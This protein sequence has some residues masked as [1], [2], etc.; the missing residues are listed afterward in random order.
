MP[1]AETDIVTDP[2]DV[3]VG[4][5]GDD[6]ST[7]GALQ[8]QCVGE[9]LHL[10]RILY[11]HLFLRRQRQ[12]R[13][14]ARVLERT[15]LVGVERHLDLDHA[16][17]GPRRI[18]RRRD[19]FGDLRQQGLGVELRLLAAR[20]NE[21]LGGAAGV[22]RDESTCGSDIDRH[23]R[24]RA[25]VDRRLLGLVVLAFEADPLLGPERPDQRDGFTQAS[26]AL[27]EFRPGLAGRRHLVESFAGADSE[28]DARRFRAE[29]A[30]PG[31]RKRCMAVDML[32]GLK[33]IAD[34]DRIEPDFLGET[35][36]AQQRA[37]CELL[38]RC[39]VSEL[40]HRKSPG[41]RRPMPR[42]WYPW[43]KSID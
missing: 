37:R 4:V 17:V 40:D 28:H 15:R 9:A 7:G 5:A 30:E 21:S 36:E 6:P 24:I 43:W 18:L 1:E 39:L 34:E 38:R 27:L 10:D 29:R 22:T 13:P 31:Q 11:R 35:G 19:A 41:W 23:R 25:V 3:L 33:V 12:R 8:R 20:A 16:I 42:P 14:V 26:E 2:L 32:P